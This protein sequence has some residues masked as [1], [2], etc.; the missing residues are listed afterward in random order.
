MS[1]L[2]FGEEREKNGAFVKMRLQRGSG[3]AVGDAGVT[4]DGPDVG[5]RLVAVRITLV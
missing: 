4:P 2:L 5:Y 3:I 1:S